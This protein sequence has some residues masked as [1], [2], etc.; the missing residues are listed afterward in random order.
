MA[1]LPA[2]YQWI[3][4][5]IKDEGREATLKV[6]VG[7]ATDPNKPWRG[8][9]AATT[10][11]DITVDTVTVAYKQNEIDGSSVK[12]TDLKAFCA[13]HLTADIGLYDFFMD[14]NGDGRTWSIEN[15]TKIEPG[16]E[17]LLYIL[18]LRR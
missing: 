3:A 7:G 14:V 4:D 8:D 12:R 16:G 15:I 13:P 6:L 1:A 11:P 18:Q 9:S 17:I 10:V 2:E 5:L